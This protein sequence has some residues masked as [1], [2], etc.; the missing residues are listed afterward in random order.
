VKNL[1]LL[2]KEFNSFRGLK[3]N[4]IFIHGPPGSGKTHFAEKMAKYYNIP[5]ILIKD[6]V[7]AVKNLQDPLGEE[8]RASWEELKEKAIEE[9]QNLFEAEKKKKKGGK[10][11]DPVE[12]FDPTKVLVRMSE[13]H[14]FKAFQWRLS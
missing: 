8:I 9:A 11:G 14:L 6:V 7:E 10:K 2:V 12:E 4:R 3:P 13:E 1:R 5:H